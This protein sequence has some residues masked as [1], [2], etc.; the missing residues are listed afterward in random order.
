MANSK[1]VKQL[2]LNDIFQGRILLKNYIEKVSGG[3]GQVIGNDNYYGIYTLDKENKYTSW[4]EHKSYAENDVFYGKI[5]IGVRLYERDNINQ[6]IRNNICLKVS[7][8]GEKTV[9]V[10]A[11]E[12]WRNALDALCATNG[13]AKNLLY[14]SK[15]VEPQ[16]RLKCNSVTKG[17]TPA[18]FTWL[19][20]LHFMDKTGEGSFGYIAAAYGNDGRVQTKILSRNTQTANELVLWVNSDN[21]VQISLTSPLAWRKAIFNNN[22]GVLPIGQGGT[23]TTTEAEI[24]HILFPS[25]LSINSAVYFY[26]SGDGSWS[27]GGYV[28]KENMCSCI[29]AVKN[30]GSDN[31]LI[32]DTS[33]IA[34]TV[35]SISS[36]R[37]LVFTDKDNR[38]T[39]YI[40]SNIQTDGSYRL[41]LG[42]RHWIGGQKDH[43]LSLGLDKTGA[44]F[45]QINALVWRKALDMPTKVIRKTITNLALNDKGYVNISSYRPTAPSG[46]TL[47]TVNLQYWSASAYNRAYH[48]TSD[49]EWFG[50]S[51]SGTF[52]INSVVLDY[53][54]VRTELY[55]RTTA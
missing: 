49:G 48:V 20:S 38:H 14:V 5:N 6:E 16:I 42:C 21:S 37:Y 9:E 25:S 53:I 31:I 44:A 10:D 41:I 39:G 35:Q 24:R 11:P 8:N 18:N 12:S 46:Y 13:E 4:F 7:R 52:T 22:T 27:P 45:L 15:D 29:G 26:G 51:S 43:I 23:G 1:I 17:T 50:S 33:K 19:G 34:N 3:A 55:S 40:D 28:S 32:K 2:K 30:G 47:L 36:E 54:Y